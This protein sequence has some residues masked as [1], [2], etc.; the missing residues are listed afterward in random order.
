MVAPNCKLRFIA[1]APSEIAAR[2][3]QPNRLESQKSRPCGRP[4]I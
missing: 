3:Q 2:W 4:M 1:A